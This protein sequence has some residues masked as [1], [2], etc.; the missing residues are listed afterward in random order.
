[1]YELTSSLLQPYFRILKQALW[2]MLLSCTNKC[3]KSKHKDSNA[4]LSFC[5]FESI[6]TILLEPV[7]E[8]KS[9]TIQTFEWTIL[10]CSRARMANS[11]GC[12]GLTFHPDGMAKC[13]TTV[14]PILSASL[15]RLR[16]KCDHQCLLVSRPNSAI[17]VVAD[18]R[19]TM[20]GRGEIQIFAMFTKS[21]RTIYHHPSL[22]WLLSLRPFSIG[23]RAGFLALASSTTTVKPAFIA[24]LVSRPTYHNDA[25][26]KRTNRRW[27]N[28]HLGIG[29]T[30][31]P[32]IVQQVSTPTSADSRYILEANAKRESK[33]SKTYSTWLLTRYP[34]VSD[35]VLMINPSDKES[36]RF[37][38]NQPVATTHRKWMK[39]GN[40]SIVRA[41]Q[42]ASSWCRST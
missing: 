10:Y 11:V 2:A 34:L 27:D 3:K 42:N 21:T 6:H 14:S 17:A 40:P 35:P 5:T 7:F 8:W 4:L 32:A 25:E 28:M 13:T 23:L 24:N 18:G 29:T 15:K 37:R 19:C 9:Q 22:S 33:W 26:N 16:R 39:Q 30:L 12:K 20:R 36:Q 1:M 31:P 38:F 41:F